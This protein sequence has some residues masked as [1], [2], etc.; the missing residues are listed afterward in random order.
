MQCRKASFRRKHKRFPR[1]YILFLKLPN[2]HCRTSGP[3]HLVESKRGWSTQWVKVSCSTALGLRAPRARVSGELLAVPSAAIQQTALILCHCE[4]G[5]G[6]WKVLGELLAL[7]LQG[8]PWGCWHGWCSACS[9]LTTCVGKK[10][11]FQSKNKQ[12]VSGVCSWE[13]VSDM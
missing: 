10:R 2:Q 7:P 9:S 3:M 5:K 8:R 11:L 6:W 12:L 4:R 1:C 13:R